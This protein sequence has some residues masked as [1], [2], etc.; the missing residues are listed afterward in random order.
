MSTPLHK[1]KLL[2]YALINIKGVKVVLRMFVGKMHRS[3]GQTSLSR[4]H[5]SAIICFNN[6]KTYKK[7]K[8]NI[9]II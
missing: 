2:Q 4:K 9:Y 1:C 6:I 8:K 5:D 3:I 7:N